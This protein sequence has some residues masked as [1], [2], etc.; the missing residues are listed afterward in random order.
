[1]TIF[2]Q[3]RKTTFF[4]KMLLFVGMSVAFLGVYLIRVTYKNTEGIT[5]LMVMAIFSW[6][7]LM[8]LFIVS[9]LNADVKTEL[10]TVLRDHM[11]ET[12]M[13]KEISHEQLDEI[14]T[15]NRLMTLQLH[16]TRSISLRSKNKKNKK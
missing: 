11:A 14:K 6:L 13:L 16:A 15:M 2:E 5:W 3:F 4:E 9:G 10:A 8:V 7:I 1:M 12:R